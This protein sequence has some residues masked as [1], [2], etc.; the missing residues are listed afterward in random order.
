MQSLAALIVAQGWAG[1]G[2]T[3]VVARGH[4][5]ILE[6]PLELSEN[7]VFVVITTRVCVVSQVTR[8]HVRAVRFEEASLGG[9]VR[10][11]NH[12]NVL[13]LRVLLRGTACGTVCTR[14]GG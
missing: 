9:S 12:L 5:H 11:D 8:G 14:K 1:V 7:A 3:P 6:V 10:D 2:G 13:I 4:L